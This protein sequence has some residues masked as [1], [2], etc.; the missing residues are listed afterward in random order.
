MVLATAR[1]FYDV[2]KSPADL[3]NIVRYH[4]LAKFSEKNNFHDAVRERS[5]MIE[6]L[7]KLAE[8]SENS[9][10]G[11]YASGIHSLPQIP[12]E[13][14]V[15]SRG[16]Q[17]HSVI[18][19][20][21]HLDVI[22]LIEGYSL[23]LVHPQS[24]IELL[25]PFGETAELAKVGE[26]VLKV[27]YIISWFFSMFAYFRSSLKLDDSVG[28]NAVTLQ[29]MSLTYQMLRVQVDNPQAVI[30]FLEDGSLSQVGKGELSLSLTRGNQVKYFHR[31]RIC[32]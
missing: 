12:A 29:G 22:K 31:L 7:R 5:K 10:D 8:S 4:W 13:R 1:T 25:I 11:K 6:D 27:P 17:S 16:K 15:A 32:E 28:I 3:D 19:Q 24:E 18:G 9:S 20:G 26:N 2:A 21:G 23:T 30:V 14:I